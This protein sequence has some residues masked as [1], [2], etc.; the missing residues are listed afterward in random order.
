MKKKIQKKVEHQNRKTNTKEAKSKEHDNED[1]RK[2]ES[3]EEVR[4]K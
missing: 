2:E 4:G 3:D 1:K